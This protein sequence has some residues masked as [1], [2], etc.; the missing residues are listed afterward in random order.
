M[1][2]TSE[3]ICHEMREVWRR[4]RWWWEAEYEEEAEEKEGGRGIER[5]EKEDRPS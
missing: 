3:K 1:N 5:E 2:S 4:G